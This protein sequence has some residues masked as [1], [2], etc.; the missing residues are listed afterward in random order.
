MV[1]P[2]VSSAL[3]TCASLLL[4]QPWKLKSYTCGTKCI[5]E[6]F[7]LESFNYFLWYS[8]Q[9]KSGCHHITRVSSYATLCYVRLTSLDNSR[10]SG[11]ILPSASVVRFM[12]QIPTQSVAFLVINRLCLTVAYVRMLCML[13]VHTYPKYLSFQ[14]SNHAFCVYT[15]VS[16]Q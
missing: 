14:E 2:Y 1:I 12:K 10:L 7:P 16:Y 11:D 8:R 4:S 13:Y 3:L 5:F 9:T 6:T 15:E